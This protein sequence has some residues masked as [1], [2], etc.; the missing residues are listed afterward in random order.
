MYNCSIAN[1]ALKV[2]PIA[3]IN[4]LVTTGI[5]STLLQHSLPVDMNKQQFFFM[6]LRDKTL[7]TLPNTCSTE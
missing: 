6:I 5:H 7:G 3:R 2:V 4:Y 1:L